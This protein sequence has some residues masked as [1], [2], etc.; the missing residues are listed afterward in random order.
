MNYLEMFSHELNAD[1]ADPE[2]LALILGG[3]H[4]DNLNIDHYVRRLDELAVKTAQRLSPD[5][6][7]AARVEAL[8]SILQHEMGFTG[9]QAD[10]YDPANSFLYLVLE[11][12]LGLPITLSLLYMAVGRRLGITLEGMGFPGHFMLRY[13]DQQGHWLLDP[14]NGKFLPAVDA[15][16]YLTSIFAQPV[17]LQE[18]LDVYHVTT[19]SLILRVLNNLR[20]IYVANQEFEQAVQV[21]DFMVLVEPEEPTFWRERGLLRFQ[22]G[23]FLEAEN[24]LRHFFYQRRLIHHFVENRPIGALQP[25]L[26]FQETMPP[27][28]LPGDALELLSVLELIRVSVARLN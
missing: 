25:F 20:A 3:M 9:N 4:N 21:L 17:Q 19:R 1:T 12:R 13:Q 5:L 18:P 28:S 2:R 11:R 14:F 10:Y 27:L 15:A 24:D 8:I 22:S 6:R 7:G 23:R 16:D 26:P